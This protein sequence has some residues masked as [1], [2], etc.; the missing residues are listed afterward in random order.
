MGWDES[1]WAEDDPEYLMARIHAIVDN[2]SGRWRGRPLTVIEGELHRRLSVFGE[3]WPPELIE[4][5]A[6]RIGDP[7]WPWK[8]PLQALDLSR[9][10]NTRARTYPGGL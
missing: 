7:H 6:R 10:Y 2:M 8:H 1:G 5:L 3:Q 9:R 4:H